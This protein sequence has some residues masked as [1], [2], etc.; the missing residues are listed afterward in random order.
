MCD[1]SWSTG[2][3]SGE[4]IVIVGPGPEAEAEPGLERRGANTTA[5]IGIMERYFTT[6][7]P[8]QWQARVKD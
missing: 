6:N 5:N 3:S 7:Q 1:S 4:A 8:F 2:G